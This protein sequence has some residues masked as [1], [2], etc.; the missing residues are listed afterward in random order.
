MIQWK[1]ILI[2]VT[3]LVISNN[4]LYSGSSDCT[5]RVWDVETYAELYCI[6]SLTSGI[7][8]L[9]VD[10]HNRLYSGSV[11]VR[12]WDMSTHNEIQCLKD[13]GWVYC[14]LIHDNKLYSATSKTTFGEYGSVKIWDIITFQEIECLKGS[15]QS[16]QCMV[17][18]DNKLYSSGSYDN[19][20]IV[21]DLSTYTKIHRLRGH[22]DYVRWLVV[23]GN[24][25]YSQAR[26]LHGKTI[27]VRVWDINTHNEVDCWQDIDVSSFTIHDN[28]LYSCSADGTV[29]L[30]KW[31][32][33]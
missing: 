17:I 29:R 26:D 24:Y 7:S 1:D 2:F 13:G 19:A 10:N 14:L 3:S 23:N 33:T 16:F 18:H 28:E 30:F 9:C 31:H 22:T 6:K 32:E 15:V 12:V 20:I 11:D 5:I 4:K 25:L 21:W 27:D 8:C